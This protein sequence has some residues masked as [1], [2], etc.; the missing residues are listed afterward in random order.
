MTVLESCPFHT[1]GLTFAGRRT[2]LEFDELDDAESR[3]RDGGD[4]FAH[5]SPP[6]H[7]AVR[8]IGVVDVRAVE[9]API[10]PDPGNLPGFQAYSG[11][12]RMRLMHEEVAPWRAVAP[13]RSPRSDVGHPD[14]GASD[15][16]HKLLQSSPA[17]GTI[18]RAHPSET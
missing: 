5:V 3:V 11:R 4:D 9:V 16:L 13:P 17:D 18:S 10:G 7:G 15:P 14:Q 12:R 2:A 1:A 6:L 8:G